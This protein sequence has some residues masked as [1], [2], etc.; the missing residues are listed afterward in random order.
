MDNYRTLAGTGTSVLV[1]KKSRFLGHCAPAQSREQA[2]DFIGA[3]KASHRDANHNVSAY[4]LRAQNINHSS[5][6]GEPSGTAGLPVLDV[7]MKARIVDAV[8]VV[9][10]Y[11]GGTL[12]GAG[13]LVRAYSS[14]ASAAVKDAGAALMVLC[15]VYDVALGYQL[16]EP[17]AKL[18][19]DMGAR[20][21]DTAFAENVKLRF[22]LRQTSESELFELVKE[23]TR[24]AVTPVLAERGYFPQEDREL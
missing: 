3:V 15:N 24:G 9:T 22:V 18:L 16:Y 8:I 12:L 11:F 20:V 10:R 14:S 21:L 1:E 17:F 2:L 23:L 19:S 6:D 13:G 7:L 5:D 4:N